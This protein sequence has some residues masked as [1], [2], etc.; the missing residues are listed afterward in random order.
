MPTILD[1][2]GLSDELRLQFTAPV[3][4]T[5]PQDVVVDRREVQLH[6]HS[7][8]PMLAGE[9]DAVRPFAVTAHYQAQWAIRTQE[10]TYL[11][12]LDGRPHELY[13]RATDLQEQQDV[14][15]DHRDVADALELTLRRF[16]DEI[17]RK[18]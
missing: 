17:E 16:A 11:Y 7:L 3:R 4:L 1:A 8:L 15:A 18:L 12:N 6:G 5:F 9:R 10:W 2:L 14:L 13:H